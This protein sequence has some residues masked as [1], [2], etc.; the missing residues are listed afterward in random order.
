MLLGRLDIDSMLS[1]LDFNDQGVYNE[2]TEI[3]PNRS[4]THKRVVWT[5]RP[6][7]EIIVAHQPRH[8]P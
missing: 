1:A 8:L 6:K 2:V 5:V 4:Q 7:T 3:T